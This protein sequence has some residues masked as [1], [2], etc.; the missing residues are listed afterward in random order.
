MSVGSGDLVFEGGRAVWKHASIILKALVTLGLLLWLIFA[1][2]RQAL[3]AI[4]RDAD[5]GLLT[6]AVAA[7]GVSY[8]LGGLRWWCVFRALGISAGPRELICAFWVG[9]LMSQVLPN[10]LG[11]A[12]RMSV[13]ARNG[14]GVREAV[15]STVVERVL[16]VVALLLL[17]VATQPML[18]V[19]IAAARPILAWGLL[20]GGLAGLGAL[21]MA[22]RVVPRLP[23][24]R[25]GAAVSALSQDVRATLSSRWTPGVVA[26][27]LL[28]NLNLILAAGVVGAAL[29]L[30]LSGSDYLAIMP[31]AMV[32][33][34]LPISVAGWGV[35]EGVMVA[36]FKAMG[37]PSQTALAFSLVYGLTIGLSALPGLAMLWAPRSRRAVIKADGPL[38]TAEQAS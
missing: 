14:I 35:R 31:L 10:P 26:A 16:M 25:L 29:H 24:S 20:A 7:L 4:V 18:H 28:G 17:L 36:L 11:D 37:L 1:V 33:M 8:I 15:N 6:L 38:A 22:D 21:A 19:R 13:A 23:L 3:L 32:A 2:D 27:S 34:V 30:R 9:G 12:V 5:L